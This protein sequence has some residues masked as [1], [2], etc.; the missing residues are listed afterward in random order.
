MQTMERES[1]G[2]RVKALRDAQGWTQDDLV[3]KSGLSR[4]SISRL[5]NEDDYDLRI[6]TLESLARA[7]NVPLMQLLGETEERDPLIAAIVHDVRMLPEDKKR[8][9][10]EVARMAL[11]RAPMIAAGR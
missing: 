11:F 9:I 3:R 4:Q 10:A 8:T 7:F 6:N 1:I 5:E 2:R